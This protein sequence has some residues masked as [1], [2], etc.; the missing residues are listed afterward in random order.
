MRETHEP[1]T[2]APPLIIVSGGF[3][4]SGSQLAQTAIAQFSE[5]NV[6]V[7]VIPHVKETAD[8]QNAV[9]QAARSHGTIVHTLVN[10]RHRTELIQ[11]ARERNVFTIDLLGTLLARL[12]S[13]LGFEPVGQ[14]GLYRQLREDYFNRVEA[15]EFAVNHDDGKRPNDLPLAEIVLVGPS[16]VG[17]TPLSMYLSVSGWKVANVPLIPEIP[18]P[19]EL[20]QLNSSRVVG[21]TID[22]AQLMT[23]RK[24][25]QRH[26]GTRGASGYSDLSS[27]EKELR[28]AE[29]VFRRGGF[30]AVNVTDRPIEETAEEVIS[31]IRRRNGL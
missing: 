21:L 16:R 17:K 31:L 20:F 5:A 24:R 4:S 22:T 13:I 23:H 18:P 6:P 26:L 15:I 11:L 29:L 1:G 30:P 2:P 28:M 3:G 8:L 19:D 25:R 9:D 7:I 14:P 12:T 10:G 27:I